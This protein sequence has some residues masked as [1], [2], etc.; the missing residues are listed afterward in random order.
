MLE[1][2]PE[3]IAH[4]IIR[5]REYDSGIDAWEHNGHRRGNGVRTE[6]HEFIAGMNDDEQAALTAVMW[7][8]RDSFDASELAEAIATA[9]AEK[10]S[11]TEDYL[12]GEP[13]LADYLEVGM[14]A[15]GMSPEEAEDDLQRPV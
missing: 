15:L 10:T 12:M 5:A 8:G 7:I 4:V 9:K 11:P 13:Q 14:D 6:L 1:I 2:S 3:K